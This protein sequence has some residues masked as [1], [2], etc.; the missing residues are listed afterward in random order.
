M[1]SM[2]RLTLARAA[3]WTLLLAGWVGLGS[4]ALAASPLPWDAFVLVALWLLALGAA[5]TVAT[6]DDLGAW[7][8][9]GALGAGAAATTAALAWTQH[10]G[11]LSAL[12]L[13]L[14]GWAALTALASGVVRSLRLAHPRRP[15]PPIGAASLGAL[16]AALALGDTGD[17]AGLSARLAVLVLGMGVALAALQPSATA[18][19]KGSRCRAGLFDCSLPAW[20]VAAWRD[21]RQWPALLAGLAM[22]PMMG[23]LPLTAAWCSAQAVPPQAMVALHLAAMFVPA[24]L[25]RGSIASWPAQRL[26]GA[27]AALLSAGAL[28]AWWASPPYDLMLAA[29][30]QGSAWSLAWAGQLWAP[31]RRGARGASPLRAAIGY[32]ALTLAIGAL[33]VRLGAPGIA[34]AHVALGATALLAWCVAIMLRTPLM[35][36]R[37]RAWRGGSGRNHA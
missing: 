18:R 34:A 4:L 10:G 29:V 25:W 22:L 26:A 37:L 30:A 8:R 12:L 19:T 5:A 17:A 15:G 1:P 14:A 2:L 21:A 31:E 35:A 24:L 33:A 32:A 6:R 27:C 36:R 7:M 16:M 9:R 3:A 28:A 20:P 13:A 11:G 23:A